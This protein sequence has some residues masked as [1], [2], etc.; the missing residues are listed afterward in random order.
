[1]STGTSDPGITGTLAA[2]EIP[3]SG[4]VCTVSP[5]MTGTNYRSWSHRRRHTMLFKRPFI[6]LL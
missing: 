3:C 1:V 5:G 6:G 2:F 4:R